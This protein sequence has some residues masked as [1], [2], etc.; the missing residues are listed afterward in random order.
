LKRLDPLMPNPPDDVAARRLSLGL[1]L[2]LI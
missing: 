1:F 2:D